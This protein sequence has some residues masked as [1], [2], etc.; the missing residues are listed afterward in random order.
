MWSSPDSA[1]RQRVD[2]LESKLHDTSI[3][4]PQQILGFK[5]ELAALKWLHEAVAAQA[6]PRAVQGEGLFKKSRFSNFFG[7]VLPQTLG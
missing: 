3:T 6:E 1:V 4:D 7:R 5:H 2:Q